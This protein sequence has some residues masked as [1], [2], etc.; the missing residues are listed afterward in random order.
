MLPS[1]RHTVCVTTDVLPQTISFTVPTAQHIV[2]R[3]IWTCNGTTHNDIDYDNT[4]DAYGFTQKSSTTTTHP[5]ECLQ[6][7]QE[8]KQLRAMFPQFFTPPRMYS[9]HLYMQL[10]FLNTP[11]ANTSKDYHD[12]FAPTNTPSTPI[13]K[14]RNKTHAHDEFLYHRWNKSSTNICIVTG[15]TMPKL[16]PKTNNTNNHTHKQQSSG[17]TAIK[18][19]LSTTHIPLTLFIPLIWVNLTKKK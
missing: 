3:P 9:W 6:W 1:T 10:Q 18:D 17:T 14:K 15:T 4:Y 11:Y 8:H 19:D 13:T 7:Q 5:H 12:N 16:K 2:H